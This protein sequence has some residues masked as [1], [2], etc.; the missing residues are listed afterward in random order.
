MGR[1]ILVC[2]FC[3]QRPTVRATAWEKLIHG[4]EVQR[5]DKAPI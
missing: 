3:D 2:T 5:L 4:L 1:Q